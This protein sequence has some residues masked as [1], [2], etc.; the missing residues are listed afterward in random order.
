M[1]I[2][3][4]RKE[5]L[6]VLPPP[7]L[8]SLTFGHFL[9]A[10]EIILDVSTSA[11]YVGRSVGSG[12]VSPLSLV[13]DGVFS[14]FVHSSFVSLLGLCFSSGQLVVNAVGE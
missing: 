9:G 8:F 1:F 5:A 2:R 12:S 10:F 4:L 7:V 13:K 6:S 3:F 11:S 14:H